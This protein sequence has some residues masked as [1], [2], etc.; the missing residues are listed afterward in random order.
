MCSISQSI[1]PFLKHDAV[2]I[3]FG[4][5]SNPTQNTS[6][7]RQRSSVRFSFATRSEKSTL[8]REPTVTRWGAS[9]GEERGI[10]RSG[11][12]AISGSQSPLE[13][14]YKYYSLADGTNHRRTLTA[15]PTPSTELLP[16]DQC[17]KQCL[18]RHQTKHRTHPLLQANH[19][20]N[21]HRTSTVQ[22]TPSIKVRPDNQCLK[23]Q[24]H[25]PDT[26]L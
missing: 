7:C 15:Q 8:I 1:A 5:R 11:A 22:Q 3:L 25:K 2:S 14:I 18:R 17:L 20:T 10:W 12:H 23:H 19:G 4:D 21:H 6:N 13:K 9:V 26:Y 16:D 24:L